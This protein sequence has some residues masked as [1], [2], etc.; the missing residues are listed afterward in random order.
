MYVS[1]TLSRMYLPDTVEK[2]VPYIEINEVQLN[3]HLPISPE[4]HQQFQK[5]TETGKALQL[6][7]K[8]VENGWPERKDELPDEVKP[9]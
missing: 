7:K 9:Y 6:L 1:D 5:Q 4:K 3:T 8:I 2:L